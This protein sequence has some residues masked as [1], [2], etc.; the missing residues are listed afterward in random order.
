[1]DEGADDAEEVRLALVMNGGAGFAV[2]MGGV[3]HELDLLRRASR[4]EPEKDVRKS[5]LPVFRFWRKVTR[6][7]AAPR[8]VRIDIIAGTSA[9]GLNGLMLATAIGRNTALTGLRELWQ[10]SAALDRL[11]AEPS[12]H[13]LF[14]GEFF[15]AELQEALESIPQGDTDV[16]K[17]ES[18]T[19]FM[20]ATA[21][22]GRFRSYTDSFGNHFNVRDRRRLYRFER[23]SEEAITYLPED[24]T[25]RIQ[26]SRPRN[27]F[28]VA[29]TGS[30][31]RVA[32]ATAG[33]PV[34]F[35]P[36]SELPLLEYR[37]LP[38]KVFDDP[39][40]CVM[41]GGVLNNAPFGPVLETITKR[42]L[43]RKVQRVVV[44]VVPSGGRLPEEKVKGAACEEATVGTAGFSA[45]GLPQEADFRIGTEDLAARLRTSVRSTRE[46]LFARLHE[47]RT[48]TGQATLPDLP[49]LARG[50]F[51]EYRFNRARGVILEMRELL[52]AA[53]TV[54]SLVFPP[55]VETAEVHE[56][57]ARR[58]G[59]RWIPPDDPDC[60]IAWDRTWRWG[61]LPA[62]RVLQ[63]LSGHLQEYADTEDHTLRPAAQTRLI[64]GAKAVNGELRRVLAVKDAVIR[65]IQRSLPRSG[66]LSDREAAQLL[67][68]IFR[69]LAVPEAV[70]A[71]V[72]DGGDH[73]AR[74]VAEAEGRWN[75]TWD[76][77][78][79]CLAIEV[80]TQSFVPPSGV[81]ETLTPHFDFLRLGPD[82]MS[83]LFNDDRFGDLGERKL[84]GVRFQHF[85]AFAEA[86]W[87]DSDFVWGRLDAAHHLLPLFLPSAEEVRAAETELHG[88]ILNAELGSDGVAWMREHLTVL[89]RSGS[90][91]DLL[92]TIPRTYETLR[93]RD[94]VSRAVF[95]VVDKIAGHR[96]RPRFLRVWL[97]RETGYVLD[98]FWRA[99]QGPSPRTAPRAALDAVRAVFVRVAVRLAVLAVV[100]LLVGVLVGALFG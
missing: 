21:L 90:D 86:G 88:L 11:L 56:F 33:F 42:P 48:G 9:G 83:R 45:L 96:V 94:A 99:S 5:D 2:W 10:R 51:S 40:S 7:G 32:R 63:T 91:L 49:A 100:L 24:G 44:Y 65:Q 68:E 31:V 37:E 6:E 25:W 29:N 64:E 87:R 76:V 26:K 4:G 71:F 1:M 12:E 79:D 18:V 69:R 93:T 27:D 16:A 17:P 13:S 78:A 47:V 50:M 35:P 60:L 14:S 54:T 98:E 73:Y 15:D 80:L 43:D 58:P 20:T 34:A 61:L 57:L 46:E 70:A 67:D 66:R 75:G 97:R 39:A 77:V 8:R 92:P 81:T 36:V 74:A 95:R 89:Q 62:E 30:L 84:Y 41:D 38:E 53:D 85:G 23:Y 82:T 28:V 22:D 19:L 59:F 55:Q 3:A 72:R 52:A